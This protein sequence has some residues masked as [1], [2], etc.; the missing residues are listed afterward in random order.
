MLLWRELT[1]E[2]VTRI[3]KFKQETGISIVSESV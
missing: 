3:N 1:A 2:E